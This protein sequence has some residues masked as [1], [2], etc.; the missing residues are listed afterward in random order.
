MVKRPGIRGSIEGLP[1]EEVAESERM[2]KE[3]GFKVGIGGY[4]SVLMEEAGRGAARAK[5][6][7]EAGQTNEEAGAA[8]AA[9]LCSSAACEARLSEYL[10]H[11]EF[12]NG[13]LPEELLCVRSN[14]NAREQWRDLLKYV[15][16]SV[17][18]GTNSSC[19]RLGCLFRLRDLVAHRNARARKLD[20]WPAGI[21]ACV[22]QG[23]IPVRKT[24]NADW[25]SVIFVSEVAEWASKVAKDW[26]EEA[27]ELAPF[28]C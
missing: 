16:P 15:T 19:L 6:A 9:I 12:A 18:L 23:V 27:D 5:A 21:E 26:L 24:E 22:K 28:E 2:L 13:E 25:T 4:D 8:A 3:G 7:L 1:E 17:D 20:T 11:Y 14:R 10:A